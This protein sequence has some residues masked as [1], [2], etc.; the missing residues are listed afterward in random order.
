MLWAVF[1]NSE[2]ST[3]CYIGSGTSQTN[4]SKKENYDQALIH[5]VS[6]SLVLQTTISL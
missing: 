3:I 6:T 1:E 5:L 4:D 2:F